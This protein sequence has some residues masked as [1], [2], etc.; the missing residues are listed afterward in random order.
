M[1]ITDIP[2]DAYAGDESPPDHSD[3]ESPESL[4]TGG[5]IRERLL[6]SITGLRSPT[7]VSAIA[8]LADCD[9]ETARDYLEWFTEMGMVHRHD[10]RPVRYERNDAYFQWR[11]ID[12]IRD[13]YTD[14]EIVETLSDTLDQIED[15][16]ARFDADG[17]ND[18]SLVKASRDMPTEDA[19]EALSEWETLERRATLLDAARRDDFAASSKSGPIDA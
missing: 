3:L 11:R 5:P 14:Q 9:T 4:L 12:R 15:Y 16:R 1:D 2:D 17:P 8:D 19:W 7:K 10:G 6:D 13:E 18:V